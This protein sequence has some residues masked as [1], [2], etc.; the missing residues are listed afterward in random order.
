MSNPTQVPRF[1]FSL[2]WLMLLV[3]VVAILLALVITAEQ[4]LLRWFLAP[5]TFFVLPTLYL[6][7]AI[8]DRGDRQSFAI[9]ALVPASVSILGA[10]VGRFSSFS[11]WI[12]STVWLLMMSAA[13]GLVAVAT[14]RWVV[15]NRGFGE[16]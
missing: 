16:D 11:G 7:V 15:Q 6:I 14:H 8:F 9:G 12:A 1:Q 3:V 5:I 13:C 2:R 4:F 10:D